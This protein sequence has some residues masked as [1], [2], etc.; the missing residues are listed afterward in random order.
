TGAAPQS[1][2]VSAPPLPMA[3]ASAGQRSTSNATGSFSLQAVAER[4]IASNFAALLEWIDRLGALELNSGNT[5]SGGFDGHALT[6]IGITNGSLTIDDRRDGQ[7]WQLKQ[8]SLRLTRQSNGGIMF[9]VLSESQERP[10]VVN[11][12]LQPLQQGHRRL[13]LEARQ[14]VLDDLLALRM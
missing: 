3:Q 10:W 11:A 9:G 12:A 6:E 1:Q 8:I 13:Q 14:V 7:D 5:E 4:G 2:A